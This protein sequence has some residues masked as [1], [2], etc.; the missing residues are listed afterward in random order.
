MSRTVAFLFDSGGG[1]VVGRARTASAQ[2]LG[3]RIADHPQV[4]TVVVATPAFHLWEGRGVEVEPDPPGPWRFGERLTSLVR[5]YTPD[6]LLYFSAGSGFLLSDA[7]L[8]RLIT[9]RPTSA[10]HAVLNNFYST[11]FGLVVPP[12]SLA[13]LTRDNPIGARLWNAGYACYELPRSAGTQ[14]DIDTPGELQILALHP[15]LPADLVE[16]LAALPTERAQRL[17]ELLVDSEREVVL[18]GRVG[19]HLA[20]WVEREAACRARIL[21]EERG[22]ESSGR[23][24]RGAVRSLI[25]ALT[26]GRRPDELVELLAQFGDAVVW[27]T[28]VLMAHLGFWP[29]PEERFASDRLDPAGV[30]NP[31]LRELTLACAQAP[32]P[33]LL[34]GHALV[35]GGMYLALELAWATMDREERFQPLPLSVDER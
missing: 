26:H 1:D 13:D 9:A 35:S 30:T 23:A 18:L 34:G 20:R 24:E 14:F 15:R 10:P 31:V 27:D 19:G 21:S 32:I 11:D 6:R 7:L 28:R 2:A 12:T 16:A 33:F 22:M 3:Q 8:D 4:E 29:P 25:G 5:T 17:L